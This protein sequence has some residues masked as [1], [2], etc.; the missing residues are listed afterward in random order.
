MD[1]DA[2][3]T[4]TKTQFDG[5]PG[6]IQLAARFVLDNPREVALL[7]MR[8]QARRIGV[9]PAT[10]T[11][12]ARHLGLQGYDDIRALHADAIRDRPE[13]F[14]GRAEDL[15]RQHDQVGAA[16]VASEMV[17]T[18]AAH[19]ANIGKGA[20]GDRLLAAAEVLAAGK[21]I[22]CMGQ[23]GSF[24]A[25]F[26]FAHILAFFSDRA[27]LIETMSALSAT[28]IL[29]AGPDDALLVVSFFPCARQVVETVAFARRQGVKVV[30]ITD[31]EAAPV[32]RMADISI[33]VG[34]RSPSFFD[35]FTPAFAACEV[36]VALVA[37]RHPGDVPAK[38]KETEARLWELKTWWNPGEDLP[39][40]TATRPE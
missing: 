25:A 19:V 21:R 3:I 37:G 14:G 29:D 16:G 38:V 12:L 33:V 17:E 22:F 4:T 10:M 11:R 13:P 27:I 7:S 23:R 20:Q 5:L 40:V 32:A 28:P 9:P 36:L 18:L 34:K 15:M 39:P 8:E 1:L 31:S 35:T 26:Q 2:F 30:V 6:R 24:P